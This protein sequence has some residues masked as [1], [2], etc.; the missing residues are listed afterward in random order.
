[1][2]FQIWSIEPN[3]Q[4]KH[5]VFRAVLI[6][7]GKALGSPLQPEHHA[8]KRGNLC[9]KT[10]HILSTNLFGLDSNHE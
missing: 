3:S 6:G 9:E 10:P 7:M 1:M 2:R 8:E 5:S 4:G